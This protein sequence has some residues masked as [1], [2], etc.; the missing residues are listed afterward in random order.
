M[1]LPYMEQT[2]LYNA[3][4]FNWACCWDGLY[5]AINSTTYS[6]K[7]KSFLCPSDGLAGIGDVVPGVPGH[8]GH[9]AWAGRMFWLK[10]NRL[11][12]S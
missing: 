3:A 4:N 1:L 12:G 8:G 11:T 9:P 10:R 5:D 2:P 7:I 6:T